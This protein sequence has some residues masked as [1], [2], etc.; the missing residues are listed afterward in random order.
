MNQ[1]MARP[2]G[3]YLRPMTMHVD[4]VLTLLTSQ[5]EGWCAHGVA[6]GAGSNP[7]SALEQLET[8]GLRQARDLALKL[9]DG[10]PGEHRWAFVIEDIRITGGP[11]GCGEDE[12]WLAYGT[13]SSW[14]RAP[15]SAGRWD[16]PHDGGPAARSAISP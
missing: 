1:A 16:A 11:A 14:G 3:A 8:E 6:I 9:K 2:P 7:A 4:L 5:A 13:L 10:P 12:R 15:G